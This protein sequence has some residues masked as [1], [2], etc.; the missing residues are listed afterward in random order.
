MIYEIIR[1]IFVAVTRRIA[2]LV[3]AFFFD[4]YEKVL[5]Y[6]MYFSGR[7]NIIYSQRPIIYSQRP[8][9]R[10]RKQTYARAAVVA[11]YPENGALPFP[12]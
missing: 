5:G 2:I 12:S 9:G 10:V 1:R 6:I 7:H 3:A 4:I 11:G 8:G